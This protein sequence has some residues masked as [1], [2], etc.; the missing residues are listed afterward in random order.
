M[1]SGGAGGAEWT[2]LLLLPLGPRLLL[3]EMTAAMLGP[4]LCHMALVAGPAAT[5]DTHTPPH[6]LTARHTLALSRYLLTSTPTPT[7][8]IEVHST[9]FHPIYDVG[10]LGSG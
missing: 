10:H 9:S 8:H 4:G 7:L 6:R 1:A 5:H 2:H 3:L